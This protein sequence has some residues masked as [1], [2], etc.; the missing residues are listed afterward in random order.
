[1]NEQITKYIQPVLQ[2]WKKQTK[3]NKRVFIG[4]FGGLLL[5]SLLIML[6]LNIKIYTELYSG[7]N[8]TEA[9]Q[10]I[11]LLQEKGIDCKLKSNGVILVPKNQVDTVRMD[12]ATQGYPKS[13]TNY[14]IFTSNTDLMTTEYEKRQL[15]I[16]QLNERLKATIETIDIIESAIVTISVPEQAGYAWEQNSEKPTA[17]VMVQ[18]KGGA[19]LTPA[20]VKGIKQLVSKSVPGMDNAQVAVVDSTGTE[21]QSAD[22]VTQMD[23]AELGMVI[24]TKFEKDINDKVVKIL[25]P[26]FGQ[27]NYAIS[28]SGIINLD[29]KIQEIISYTPSDEKNNTGVLEEGSKNTEKTTNGSGA[30]GANGAAGTENNTE[31]T[32]SGVTVDDN[33]VYIKNNETYKYLVNKV[34]E[35]V[36]HDS[37]VLDKLFVAV[38][39]N[40]EAMNEN[41]KANIQQLVATAAATDVK[42][43][44]VYNNK[45]N[46]T[47]NF[48]N[49]NTDDNK[50]ALN[51]KQIII[52]A[53]ALGIT[54]IV[55]MI[56]IFIIVKR[57]KRH[58]ETT[59]NTKES[60]DYTKQNEDMTVEDKIE[61]ISETR[62]QKMK[63]VIQEFSRKNPEIIAQLIRSWLKEDGK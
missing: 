47:V 35:Q 3:R 23:L 20:Q 17:S 2:F 12:L 26:I 18:T 5:F 7:L 38:T 10:V 11:Q 41:E 53:S 9:S 36:E 44:Y 62:Q 58:E 15:K 49:E 48:E 14:D 13:A 31:P 29:K 16:Y 32:Y 51:T 61:F 42:N 52:M 4:G 33:V 28:V 1:M 43:V 39:I 27:G 46:G 30:S 25:N 56:F 55:V 50:T 54:L 19:A 63:E 59:Y 8:E 21:L 6:I 45:F 57:K 22:D 34:T 60:E 40:R 24:K 37:A